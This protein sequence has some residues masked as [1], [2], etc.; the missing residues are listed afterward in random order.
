[1]IL[2][3]LLQLTGLQPLEFASITGATLADDAPVPFK[4]TALALIASTLLKSYK[5][6]SLSIMMYFGNEEVRAY[7]LEH[8]TDMERDFA[9]IQARKSTILL[10]SIVVSIADSRYIGLIDSR[11]GPNRLVWD[12]VTGSAVDATV[13]EWMW[14]S[15]IMNFTI[16]LLRSRNFMEEY[17]NVGIAKDHEGVFATYI[18]KITPD[19]AP[20]VE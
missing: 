19:T 7:L 18:D 10:H 4:F 16:L 3:T 5:A 15:L 1:M 6:Q 20:L 8:I 13:Y 9:S 17:P 12:I 11:G 2:R 14:T